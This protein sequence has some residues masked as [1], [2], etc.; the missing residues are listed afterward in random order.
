MCPYGETVSSIPSKSR[1][2]VA[3]RCI[4]PHFRALGVY[5][6]SMLLP[7]SSLCSCSLSQWPCSCEGAASQ[8]RTAQTRLGTITTTTTT[9]TSTSSSSSIFTHSATATHSL[10][11]AWEGIWHTFDKEVG[12]NELML[13]SLSSRKAWATTSHENYW[14]SSMVSWKIRVFLQTR[15]GSSL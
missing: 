1:P 2:L 10:R 14:W 11:D 7:S 4:T 8:S 3:H 15:H 5:R 13:Y 6:T 12:V 9:T